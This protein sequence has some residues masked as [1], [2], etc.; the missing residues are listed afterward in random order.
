M[1]RTKRF[2][3]F[4]WTLSEEDHRRLAPRFFVFMLLTPFLLW[5]LIWLVSRLSR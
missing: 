4:W 2:G 3:M 1:K 5:G